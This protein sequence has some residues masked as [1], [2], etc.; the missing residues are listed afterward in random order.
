[1][2]DVV[3]LIF[4]VPKHGW[5]PVDFHYFDFYINFEASDAL[6]DPIKE[7]NEVI[8]ESEDYECRQITWYSEPGAIIFD[9]SKAGQN[10][11]LIITETND[12]HNENNNREIL[13]KIETDKKQ[14]IK[15]F[16]TAVEQFYS[17]TYEEIHWTFVAGD[18]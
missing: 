14:I 17:H 11:T 2:D 13:I 12:L 6:N 18:N 16:R 5:L 7:L 3:S 1:M 9:I 8:D 4:G 15:S 10:I